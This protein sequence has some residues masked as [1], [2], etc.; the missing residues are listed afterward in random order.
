M[1]SCRSLDFRQE[2]ESIFSFRAGAGVNIKVCSGANENFKGP[3]KIFVMMLVV[4][5]NGSIETCFLTSVV[6]YNKGVTLSGSTE[7]FTTNDGFTNQCLCKIQCVSDNAVREF[8]NPCRN[9]ENVGL[10]MWSKA[11]DT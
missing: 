9:D 5:Q 7:Y 4:K 8:R 10:V 1:D 6:I 11:Q 2:P 3:I